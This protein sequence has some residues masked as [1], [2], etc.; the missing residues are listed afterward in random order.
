VAVVTGRPLPEVC[1]L[2]L[3]LEESARLQVEA[4]KLGIPKFVTQ[5][6]A[7]RIA[8]RTFKPASTERAWDH[9]KAKARA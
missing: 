5:Q 6:E 7:E 2:A 9:F 4:M 3:Y 1:I 8:K